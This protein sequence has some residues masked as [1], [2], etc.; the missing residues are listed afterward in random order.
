MEAIEDAPDVRVIVDADHHL[1]LTPAHEVG[2]ALILLEKEIHA[3]A[4]GL[5]VR[6]VHVE[7]RVRSIIAFGASE[8]GQVL[9][10]GAGEALE[11]R[12]RNT[13]QVISPGGLAR[14][15]IRSRSF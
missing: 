5:P 2:H 1:A 10:V 6:R 13:R 8:P 15:K 7:E 11:V 12:L 14:D 9:D 3:I 4:G